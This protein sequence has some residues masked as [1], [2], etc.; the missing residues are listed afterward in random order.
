MMYVPG[1][2]PKDFRLQHQPPWAN[3]P[4]L[5]LPDLIRTMLM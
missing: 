5:Q 4:L 1:E 2:Y 3:I